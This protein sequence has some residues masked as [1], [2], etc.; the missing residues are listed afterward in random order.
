VTSAAVIPLQQPSAVRPFH[1]LADFFPLIEGKDFDQ[2]VESIK[3][4]GQREAIVIYEDM[5]LDGRN[6]ARA[7]HA[8][9]VAPR[10]VPFK[11]EDPVSFVIDVNVNRRNH[12]KTSDRAFAAATLAN[13]V[14]GGKE[15]NSAKLQNCSAVSQERAAQLFNVSVRSVAT[16]AKVMKAAPPILA[17]V[18]SKDLSLLMAAKATE[19]TTEIQ[20]AV[21]AEASTRGKWDAERMIEAELKSRQS[22]RARAALK[23]ERE[24]RAALE[25]QRAAE[26]ERR[27]QKIA[28]AAARLRE[29]LGDDV[30]ARVIAAFSDHDIWAEDLLAALRAGATTAEAA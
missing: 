1:P 9:G 5:I 28:H 15:A 3:T 10:Y 22:P 14:V 29:N 26:K 7:C 25:Q 18:K 16:A 12:L 4:N 2:L 24:Q 11:G 13:M 30:V 27:Q 21:A 17:A 20:E 23:K 19:L 8:A 6:R